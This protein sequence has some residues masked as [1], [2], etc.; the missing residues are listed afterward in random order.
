MITVRNTMPAVIR[1]MRIQAIT[2]QIGLSAKET[3]L[4]DP[5][6]RLDVTV[7]VPVTIER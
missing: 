4:D 6:Q 3:T 2:N 5:P 1:A 7:I